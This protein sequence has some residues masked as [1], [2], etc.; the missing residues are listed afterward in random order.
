[1][2]EIYVERKSKAQQPE[3]S[4]IASVDVNPGEIKVFD[5]EGIG[6]VKTDLSRVN[7]RLTGEHVAKIDIPR[8]GSKEISIKRSTGEGSNTI[9]GDVY[10]GVELSGWGKEKTRCSRNANQE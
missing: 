4:Y 8:I 7:E 1:M 2:L 6:T 3:R 5:L 9:R 10:L